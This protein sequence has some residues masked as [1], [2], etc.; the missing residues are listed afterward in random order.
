MFFVKDEEK[1]FKILYYISV[2]WIDDNIV[3]VID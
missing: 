3:V 2:V 1:E